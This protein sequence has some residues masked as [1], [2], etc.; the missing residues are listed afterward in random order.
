MWVKYVGLPALLFAIASVGLP[1]HAQVVNSQWV[2]ASGNWN[3]ATNWNPN[4][5]P[6]NNGA[7]TTYNVQIGTL[8]PSNAQVT[9]IPPTGTSATIST[10]SLTDGADLFTNGSQLNVI[11]QTT[12]DGAG[13]TVRIDPHTT[14]GTAALNTGDLDLNNGGALVM[15][16]GIANVSTLFEVNVGSVLAGNGIV[17]VGDADGVVEQAFENSG[18]IQV[19]GDT[20]AARTLTIHANGVDTIDLDG[21]TETG[22]VDV[23]NAVANTNLDTLTLVVDGPLSDSFGAAAG[24]TLQIGQRDTVMFNRDFQISAGAAIQMNGGNSVATLNGA[25]AITSIAGAAFTVSGAAVIDNDMTFTGTANT[26]T[27]PTGSSLTLNGT[28]TIPDASAIATAGTAQVIIGGSTTVTEAAGDYDWDG[29]GA[30]TTTVKGAGLFTLNVS[31]IDVGN[32]VFDGTLNLNDDGDAAINPIA[33]TWTMSGTLNKNNS[34]TSTLSGKAVNVSGAVNVHGGILSTG[35]ITFAAG[36]HLT[37]DAGATANLSGTTLSAGSNITV[38]GTLSLGTASVLAGPTTITGTGL[39]RLNSTSSVT[40]NTTIDTTSFDW[41]G[42]GSGTTHTINDGVVFTVNSTIWDADD[43][44]DVDDPINLGGS[45]AQIIVNNVPTWTM[46]RTLTANTSGLGIA[47]LGG[48]SRLIFSGAT[49]ILTANGQTVADAPLTFGTSSTVNIAAGGFVRLNGGN[50]V[51][52]FNQI[53]GGT[54]NGPGTFTAAANRVFQGFGT[55]NASIDFDGSAELSASGGTLNV[56]SSIADVG[57]IGTAANDGILNVTPAWNSSVADNVV[58]KGGEIKG[59]AITV[60][61]ANGITG[62]GLVSSRVV[63]NTQLKATDAGKT[64]VFETA[65][66]DNDWDGAGNIGL[67]SATGG[68]TLEVR[69]NA[70]FSYGGTV[71]ATSGSR[72]YAKGFGFNFGTM[73]AINLTAATLDSDESASFGGAIN[74][75][76]G[77]DSTL[78]VQVNRFLTL[79]ST[80]VSTLNAN[81]RLESNNA[82]IQAGAT[83]SGSGAVIVPQN[84]HLV[85]DANANINTLLDNEGTIRPAGFDTVG[86]VDIKDYQQTNTGSLF[87]ELTGTL[88]NQ[89]DR[90][91]VNG[92][93]VL[94]GYLNI[95]IDGSFIPTLGQTFNIITAT[96]VTGKFDH[97]DVSGVPAGVTFHIN[98][99]SNA[100]QLQVVNAVFNSADFDHDG[101]VDQ[102]DYIIWRGAFNL[103]QLGDA[104]GDGKSDAADYTIWRDH[105]GTI[106]GA[107][108]G[109]LS[110]SHI[111]EPPSAWIL[112]FGTTV[113]A[114][115]RR[116]EART[117]LRPSTLYIPAQRR[118]QVSFC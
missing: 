14:L 4:G 34:G 83:F 1:C 66:N 79:A 91:V 21:D 72:V 29:G 102:T 17:N 35:T 58:L 65:A 40:A 2:P 52:T 55:I 13:T 54:I 27:V 9:F 26:I 71:T 103:N 51:S 117:Q 108:A 3:L 98:Y 67:L 15:N 30:V 118:R 85:A 20:I 49:A 46:A 88:L 101:D 6:N 50:A 23:D 28:V 105:F 19:N 31:H 93:A 5:V 84:S 114:L 109:S 60:A 81:L 89:F 11:T 57:T 75:L 32:D 25:G 116:G 45:G 42:V 43:A 96:S 86:R 110:A 90:F 48:N 59:G 8:A 100:V 95:D 39:F 94:D 33:A 77:G 87:V 62:N 38:N 113:L 78:K 44:G 82:E 56:S 41:D 10:L 18:L 99:L 12:V 76:S 111:P 70:T 68:G 53:A 107:G 24:A 74:T 64:L 92:A 73:S 63:N 115:R 104:N 16:G 106:S 36:S 37:V 97:Y 112:T 61:N 47:T 80:S 22:V 7:I 69:D